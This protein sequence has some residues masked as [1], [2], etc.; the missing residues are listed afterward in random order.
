MLLQRLSVASR[1]SPDSGFFEG[2]RLDRA[3]PHCFFDRR[4]AALGRAGVQDPHDGA[5]VVELKDVRSREYAVPV[6]LTLISIEVY[7]HRIFLV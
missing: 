3:A 1:R 6:A 4:A 2:E 5:R 7:P